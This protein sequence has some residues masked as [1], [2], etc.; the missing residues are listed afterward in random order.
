MTDVGEEI[1]RVRLQTLSRALSNVDDLVLSFCSYTKIDMEKYHVYIKRMKNEICPGVAASPAECWIVSKAATAHEAA[2]AR[3]SDDNA[4]Q[5]AQKIGTGMAHL[6]NIIEDARIEKAIS[7]IFPGTVMWFRYTNNYIIQNRKDWGTGPEAL[8]GAILCYVLIG[9]IPS[10]IKKQEDVMD[11]LGKISDL[12][13]HARNASSTWDVLESAKNIWDNIK[14]FMR[15]Y[16]PHKLPPSR[17]GSGKPETNP[18]GK[19]DPR[20]KPEPITRRPSKKENVEPKTNSKNKEKEIDKPDNGNMVNKANESHGELAELNESNDEK[21]VSGKL[22]NGSKNKAK[23]DKSKNGSESSSEE[24]LSK[25]KNNKKNNNEAV[26][27]DGSENELEDEPKKEPEEELKLDKP[28]INN[29]TSKSIASDK[30]EDEPKEESEEEEPCESKDD[31]GEGLE[32]NLG[33]PEINNKTS[34]SIASDK[35]EDE[36]KEEPNKNLKDNLDEGLEDNLGNLDEPEDSDGTDGELKEELE[37]EPGESKDD[38][39]EG[40][41]DNLDEPDSFDGTESESRE[42]E[43][44]E[45]LNELENFSQDF[46]GFNDD[47]SDLLSRA[48]K[49]LESI[50]NRE[51]IIKASAHDPV[52]DVDPKKIEAEISEIFSDIHKNIHLV[53]LPVDKTPVSKAQARYEEIKQKIFPLLK[54]TVDEIQKALLYK[55]SIREY[56][57]SKGKI[58]G[59]SLWKLNTFDPHVFY[60]VSQ[61]SNNPNVTIYILVDCSGSMTGREKMKRAR[62]AAILLHEACK[63][64]KIP[65]I[66]TGFST[67]R[68]KE[69]LHIPV[70]KYA[71]KEKSHQLIELD[72]M[73]ENRDGYSIRVATHELLSLPVSDKN[74][75]ILMVLSDGIPRDFSDRYWNNIAV[76][77]TAKSVREAE[78]K[79]IK[80]IGIYFGSERDL[81]IAQK[82]YNNLIYIKELEHLPAII[83][84]VLKKIIIG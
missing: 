22:K 56:A 2:H 7:N 32:G 66:I 14:D 4:W 35:P 23:N 13:D 9:K 52:L 19:I 43:P 75:K 10:S 62:E 6:V 24:E 34:K 67:G 17:L 42:E 84:R 73:K 45:D 55:V 26:D 51:N 53:F 25:P 82:M 72:S 65:H 69:V 40:L 41:E 44:E 63:E 64:L 70:I 49:E 47:C 71:E 50:A 60:S 18:G 78:K 79:E 46:Q 58:H 36:P 8:Y 81:P 30:P 15:M 11:R 83:G 33:E 59:G 31:L 76:A 21:V 48:K 80:V 20:W 29:K 37:E 1:K 5:E 38:L 57:K 12:L 16:T 54:K 27:F 3:Y 77:D 74:T 28:E 39:D 61:P 68:Y